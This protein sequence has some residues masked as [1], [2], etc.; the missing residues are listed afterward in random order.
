MSLNG[1]AF[2]AL[3]VNNSKIV[4]QKSS[5][6]VPDTL[7]FGQQSLVPFKAGQKLQWKVTSND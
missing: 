3:P 7:P 2:Y 4:L 6:I 5:W 1:P